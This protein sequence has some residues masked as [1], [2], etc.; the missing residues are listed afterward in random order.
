MNNYG[1]YS[2]NMYQDNN[3]HIKVNRNPKSYNNKINSGSVS[4]NHIQMNG[5]NYYCNDNKIP[6]LKKE[7]LI[8]KKINK[9]KNKLPSLNN[10]NNLSSIL[11][12][13]KYNKINNSKK[14]FQKYKS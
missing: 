13:Q 1:R 2:V 7:E 14:T 3:F 12:K 6:K 4:N 10:I 9:N 5:P 8:L 11:N